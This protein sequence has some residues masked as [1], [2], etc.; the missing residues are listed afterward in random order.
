[1]RK[2]DRLRRVV[3]LYTLFSRNLAY[4]RAGHGRLTSE[5][6]PFWKTVDGN[7]LDMAVLAR[8]Q[9]RIRPT[10]RTGFPQMEGQCVSCW[11]RAR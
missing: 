9:G 1:M 4:Y 2:R 3:L 7:F 6:P 8:Q 11:L 10:V 5:S